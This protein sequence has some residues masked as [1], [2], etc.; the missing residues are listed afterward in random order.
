[1]GSWSNDLE[2][3][4]LDHV[5][6]NT[7]MSQFTNLYLALSTADLTEDGSGLAEPAAGAY[8]RTLCN[9]WGLAAA[10]TISNDAAITFPQ[11]TAG[12]GT[13]AYWGIYSAS[14]GGT[15]IAYGDFTTSKV[16]ATGNTPKVNIGDLD[17]TGNAGAMS[18]YLV[19]A[20][21]D[22]V[23][24]NTSFTQPATLAI[25]LSTANPGDSESGLAEPSG[26]NYARK[27]HASWDSAASG[28]TENTGVITFN[29]ATGSWGTITYHC[30]C[31]SATTGGGNILLYGVL[32]SS[33]PVT[34]DDV[35]EYADGALD[36]TLD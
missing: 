3:D 7:S 4:L 29:T 28:A 19:N 2:I 16:V 33:Q 14:S 36:V 26:N 17:V 8:A 23:F 11:A 13:I 20:L 25:A 10:R 30:I 22:H 32:D 24:K 31:D 34:T 9:S 21:L 1:M 18:T 5:L 27:T 12:W 15:L 6:G 35:V